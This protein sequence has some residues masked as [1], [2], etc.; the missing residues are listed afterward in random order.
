MKKLFIALV[1]MFPLTMSM[2]ACEQD[3]YQEEEA[4]EED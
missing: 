3:A 1:L 2:T 4:V